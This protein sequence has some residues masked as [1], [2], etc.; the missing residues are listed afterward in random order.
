MD[1]DELG[2]E[3]LQHVEDGFWESVGSNGWSPFVVGDSSLGQGSG[4]DAENV[5]CAVGEGGEALL[6]GGGGRV[7][8]DEDIGEATESGDGELAERSKLSRAQRARKGDGEAAHLFDGSYL[9]SGETFADEIRL[10]RGEIPL[11]DRPSKV[12]EES[13]SF[14]RCAF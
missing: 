8:R 9:R 7:V 14:W 6:S 11:K 13:L 10:V 5:A 1:L 4:E 3:L 12:R 2:L